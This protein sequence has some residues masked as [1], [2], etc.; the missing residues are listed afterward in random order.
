MA[1]MLSLS[2]FPSLLLHPHSKRHRF[3]Y[4]NFN[5]KPKPAAAATSVYSPRIDNLIDSVNIADDITQ[6]GRK[7]ND[8]ST[9][10][11]L[12][13]LE[14]GDAIPAA[15]V[16][17][18][19]V[20]S[21]AKPDAGRLISATFALLIASTTSLL[22]TKFGGKIIDIVSGDIKTP[23]QKAEAYDAVKNTIVEIFLFII[24]GERVVAQL[25]KSLFSHLVHQ[26]IAFFDITRTGELLSRLSEDTQII[27]SAATTSLSEAL[28]SLATAF[29]G[30]SFMFAT[31]WKLTLFVLAVVP[32]LSVGVHKFGLFLTELSSKTQ[33]AAAEASSIAEESFGAIRTMRSFAQEGYEITCY[34]EKV[35]ET[36]KLRLQQ[37]RSTIFYLLY[38]DLYTIVVKAVGA[39]R[40]VFQLLDCVS[41]MPMSGNKCPLGDQDGELELDVWFAYPSR[42]NHMILKGV[43]LK[44]QPGSKVALVGPSGGGKTTIANL[45]ERFYDPIKGKI[46]L[47][48]VPLV[49]ISHEHLHRKISIVSQEPVLFNC[50]IE[51]NIA[52]GFDG[53]VNSIDL[54]NVAK[55]ANAHEFIS[56]FLDKYQT[57]VGER[58][59]RLSGG[60]K[61]RVAI[62]RALL[63]NPRILLLDEVTSA[64]DS[65]SE[66][67][68]QDAMDSLMK[69]RTVLVIAHRLS[70][71]KSANIVAVVSD[72]QIVKSGT[73][74]ELI[75][76]DGVYTALV[77]RQL[78]GTKTE[79]YFWNII[80]YKQGW[81]TIKLN[82]VINMVAFYF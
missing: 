36:F 26:E 23:E 43:T 10:R 6:R 40:R 11:Q 63:M 35:D 8:A 24:V 14:H 66:Y 72:G 39:S 77:R 55:M 62:A 25:R 45:I 41:P 46:L 19:R 49:E 81:K 68:V 3:V 51:E 32:A 20:I 31:S 1:L 82:R 5:F 22:I 28:R 61:Q 56:K 76:N 12:T 74:D 4:F 52:C 57:F 79:I 34:S 30:L 38:M 69:G 13:D 75:A 48:G 2:S 60:Q 27:K 67:L 47:N 65:E 15:N 16:G 9:D 73:H 59:V 64:L 50:S 54:E 42:P 70:T 71:V 18:C 7:R 78:Q 21:L 53:K 17:F 58:G 29:F 44:L 37:A 33:A 80:M